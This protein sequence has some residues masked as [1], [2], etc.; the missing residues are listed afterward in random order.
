MHV[1]QALV[2][3]KIAD[4]HECTRGTDRCHR[5][6]TCHNTEGSY[7]CSC[8]TGYTGNGFSCTSKF[9]DFPITTATASQPHI[10]YINIQILMSASTTMEVAT[11]L[12]MT[13]MEVT[14]VPAVMD[15]CLIVM[16]KHV[17]VGIY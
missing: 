16:D 6:A 11:T 15:T 12:A 13:L 5:H 1:T 2:I 10:L 14:H 9:I 7:Y 8:N 3:I 4:I 17:K